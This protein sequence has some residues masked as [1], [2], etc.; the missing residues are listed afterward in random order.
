MFNVNI[1]NCNQFI[2]DPDKDDTSEAYRMAQ[3]CGSKC[4]QPDLKSQMLNASKINVKSTLWKPGHHTT[5]E[6]ASHSILFDIENIP[7]SMI[8]FGL[9]LI[10]PF[11]NSSQ[12]SG[13]YCLDIFG[14]DLTKY[15]NHILTFLDAF[16]SDYKC[17]DRIVDWFTS[18]F[19]FFKENIDKATELAREALENER[20]FYQLDKDAQARRIAQE[21]LRVFISTIV[22]TGINYTIN[23]PT[24][25]AMYKTAWNAPLQNLLKNMVDKFS[26]SSDLDFGDLVK[27]GHQRYELAF[28]Q[29]SIHQNGNN[30]ANVVGDIDV[31]I[32]RKDENFNVML[33][34]LYSWNADSLDTAFFDPIFVPELDDDSEIISRVTIPVVTFGQD[35]R[36]RMI[37]RSNPVIT[38]D[39][40]LPPMIGKIPGAYDFAK[41]FM[42]E[43]NDLVNIAPEAMIFF[44]PY[45]AMV[46]YN[47]K[48][49]VRAYQHAIKK[50]L[51]F[52]AE[53]T[54]S[55]M[56]RKTLH[57]IFDKLLSE[58]IEI[59][60]PCK[61]HTCPE[62]KRFCG[63]DLQN[64]KQRILI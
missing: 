3:W 17:Q 11:Y 64:R 44:I 12:R 10:H 19:I 23:I 21:Q 59:G 6:H 7:V 20:P 8:T 50:R 40:Y 16:F 25:Y 39:F 34:H 32:L 35:Q 33:K 26:E 62:G 9:H 43:F 24:L 13:R 37:K 15:R 42:Q 45:G 55:I 31:E 58:D 54:I 41:S 27:P 49:D 1:M 47:K 36:H 22:P 52:N 4:Y 29:F 53:R 48:C 46:Q 30:I 51:C 14:N 38:G 18:G 28:K 2:T 60:P 56:E 57:K 5:L 61:D 63:R